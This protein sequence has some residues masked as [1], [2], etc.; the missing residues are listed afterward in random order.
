MK[1]DKPDSCEFCQRHLKLTFHHLVPKK[2]HKD[3]RVLKLFPDID[4]IHYGI[5]L[6]VACHKHLHQNFNHDDLAFR[7]NKK[8]DL[9]NNDKIKSF[10]AWASKQRKRIK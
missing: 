8:D 10:T 7:L 6:C 9:L 4:L 1:P 2:V 5:W 3:R